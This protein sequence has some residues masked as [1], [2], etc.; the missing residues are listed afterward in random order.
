M[1]YNLSLMK[2]CLHVKAGTPYINPVHRHSATVT[3]QALLKPLRQELYAIHTF[4]VHA[5][6]FTAINKLWQRKYVQ[7][8]FI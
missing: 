6:Y 1:Y 5:E 4:S 3:A 7:T 8:P 2:S